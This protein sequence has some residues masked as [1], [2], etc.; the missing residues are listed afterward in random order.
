[1]MFSR[2]PPCNL[3]FMA[4]RFLL[5]VAYCMAIG[6]IIY[7]YSISLRSVPGTSNTVSVL[8]HIFRRH[9]WIMASTSPPTLSAHR[10]RSFRCHIRN[11]LFFLSCIR[12]DQKTVKKSYV[13]FRH[14]R[15]H[16]INEDSMKSNDASLLKKEVLRRF[17]TQASSEVRVQ[18]DEGHI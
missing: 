15:R 12:S 9:P 5:F 10:R 8:L 11:V 13:P 6:K 4:Q 1:M 7:G 14:E 16:H 17:F 2:W 3:P 18:P